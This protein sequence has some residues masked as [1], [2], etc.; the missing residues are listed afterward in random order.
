MN[1]FS[2]FFNPGPFM[3]H[4]HCYFWTSSLIALHAV[5]DALILLAYYSIPFTLVY[6]VRKRKDLKFH[7]M[8]VCFAVFILACGTTHLMAIWNVWHGDYWLSGAVKAMTAIASVP[9][10]ILLVRLI[11]QPLTLHTPYPFQNTHHALDH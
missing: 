6:F 4:G 2:N 3:P 5:S 11:P 8:F 1:S 9:P 7:W 10:A